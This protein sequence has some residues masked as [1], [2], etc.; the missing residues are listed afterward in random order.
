MASPRGPSRLPERTRPTLGRRRLLRTVYGV[1][2]IGGIATLAIGW[3]AF[4]GG[5]ASEPPLRLREGAAGQPSR[6]QPPFASPGAVDADLAALL[7]SGLMRLDGDGTPVP[8]L[9]ERWEVTPD[10][11]TYTFV[12][13]SRL[14]WHDGVPL[15]ARDVAFTIALLQAE[16]PDGPPALAAAWR[17]V[18]VIVPDGRTVIAHL[19]APSV[20]FLAH[21]TVAILPRDRSGPP[22]SRSFV[23]SGP[24]RLIELTLSRAL[25]ERNPA[26]HLG[27]PQIEEIE[28]RFYDDVAA[29]GVAL[30]AGEIDSALLP[31][32][33]SAVERETIERH[34]E[35]TA[36]PLV[37][38]G[39]TVL[40]M[41]NQ[42]APLNDAALRG[43]IAAAIDPRSPPR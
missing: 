36:L 33:P 43:A 24:Y 8:D 3:Y 31:A 7:Y 4:A 40:Y 15:T 34:G 2:L 25:L 27:T 9:A 1:A 6:V 13:R 14:F 5:G 11:L 21:A 32:A 23:G 17:G 19:P 39:Y 38:S 37:E 10:G 22:A 18:T 29:L 35:Y 12:L 30:A 41:N 28:L 20:A 42:Q 16:R 26:Y